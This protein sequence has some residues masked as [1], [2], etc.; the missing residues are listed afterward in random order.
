MRYCFSGWRLASASLVFALV[1]CSDLSSSGPGGGGTGGT[2]GVGGSGGSGGTPVDES[3]YAA[4]ELWLCRPDISSNQCALVDLST[5]EVRADGTLVDVGAP[6]M[7]P[8]SPIDCFYLYDTRNHSP[9]P[10]NTETLSPTDPGVLTA[11]SRNG[12]HFRGVCRVFAPLYHQMSISTYHEYALAWEDTP[13]FQR[14]YDDVVEAFEYYMRNH[15][16]GRSFVLL[17]HSQGSHMLA[18]LL[19]DTF[20][21]DEALRAQLLSAI[22]I[23]P[24]SRVHVPDGE[25]VGGSFANIPLCTSTSQ[26][27]C[28]ITF[29]AIA[30]DVPG[31]LDFST[32]IPP[33]MVR[34][35][36]NP[37]SFDSGPGTMAALSYPR[38]MRP[39]PFLDTVDTEWVSYPNIYES[40]CSDLTHVLEI[41]LVS[42][43]P[44]EEP[45]TPQE[46]QAA[47]EES[48]GFPTLHIAETFIAI[49]DLVRIVEQQVQSREN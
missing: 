10:G 18:R 1:A 41:D 47:I 48:G 44:R 46:L 36:V 25:Q 27:G 28:V 23:G 30:A 39:F 15:N 11:L 16:H 45:F 42:Q 34:A 13:I 3:A 22:L 33:G 32:L 5:T 35:C 24:T 7:N 43:D 19:E 2:G 49:P 12:A 29:D 26:T 14:A 31:G 9:T 21:N 40:R 20:D 37:A 6:A 17:G 8:D 38:S 4:E